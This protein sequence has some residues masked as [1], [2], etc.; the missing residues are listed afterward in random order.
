VSISSLG[1]L[2]PPAVAGVRSDPAASRG[3]AFLLGGSLFVFHT[4]IICISGD[5]PNPSL[6]FRNLLCVA[7]LGRRHTVDFTGRFRPIPFV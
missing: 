7:P 2:K 1:Y 6:R 5:D 3:M 4:D